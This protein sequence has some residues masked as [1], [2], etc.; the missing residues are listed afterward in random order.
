MRGAAAVVGVGSCHGRSGEPRRRAG[1]RSSHCAPSLAAAE[2]AGIDPREIDGFV[3]WGSE[4]NAGQY[5]MSGLGMRELALRRAD[6]GARRRQRRCD[7]SRRRARSREQA[8]VVVVIRAMAEKSARLAL[9]TAVW[10]GVNPRAPARPRDDRAGTGLRDA[11]IPPARWRRPPREA[12]WALVRA[13]YYHGSRNPNAYGAMPISTGSRT[14]I[15]GARPS[16]CT[17]STTP[18]ENDCAI[19]LILVS[20]DRRQGPEAEAGVRAVVDRWAATA[21]GTE[22]GR[23]SGRAVDRRVP[24]GRRP[25]LEGVRVQTERRGR[26][27]DLHEREQRSGQR[28][29]RSRLLL[30]GRRRRVHAR[31]RTSSP[32][33]GGCR[34]TPPVAI[35][36]DGFIHGAANNTE[37]VRQIRGTS[38][39]QVPDAK[40]SLV[41][42]GPNDHFVTTAA[43][44]RGHALGAPRP[45][46]PSDHVHHR[47][48]DVRQRPPTGGHETAIECWSC[49]TSASRRCNASRH[50]PDARR[51]FHQSRAGAAAE[52]ELMRSSRSFRSPQRA[53]G[54]GEL[55]HPRG[56]REVDHRGSSAGRH[57][58]GYLNMCQHRGG[59]VERPRRV[60]ARLHRQYHGWSYNRDDGG[61]RNVPFGDDFGEIDHGVSRAVR[62]AREERHGL[63]WV[64]LSN[65]HRSVRR[66]SWARRSTSRWQ[67]TA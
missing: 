24:F 23:G 30:V 31:S 11:R 57:V 50:R 52:I 17:C 15:R 63:L 67:F 21:A 58:G 35:S 38:P 43:R 36:A 22:R 42:G 55:H 18:P 12:L 16:R 32:P 28:D 20:A 40:L 61:L 49:T 4:K 54:T 44:E 19:A 3:S 53:P 56:A 64:D 66:S 37:A 27:P 41:C 39:N 60:Q 5:L 7:R 65:N 47:R 46:P 48:P 33:T 1:D 29:H 25:V 34:S 13:S 62:R 26:R 10:Q 9:A 51:A 6:V 2:D 45:R 59:K 14:R 8:D